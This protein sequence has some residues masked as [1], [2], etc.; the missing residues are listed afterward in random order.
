MND[1]TPD[2]LRIK[3]RW[4]TKRVRALEL[5]VQTLNEYI[6]TR[7]CSDHFGKLPRGGCMLCENERL[8]KKLNTQE[9]T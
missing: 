6:G 2:Q 9:E 3:L 1:E 4:H 7:L 5:Q 8:A